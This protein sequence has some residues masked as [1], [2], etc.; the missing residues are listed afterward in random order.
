MKIIKSQKAYVKLLIKNK[1][2]PSSFALLMLCLMS[3]TAQTNKRAFRTVC[4]RKSTDHVPFHAMSLTD[5]N[6]QKIFTVNASK[7]IRL[8]KRILI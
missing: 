5:R 1:G 6:T 7:N 8:L 2:I 3:L 4:D